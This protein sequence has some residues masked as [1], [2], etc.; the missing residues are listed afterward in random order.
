MVN[1][2]FFQL[3]R[4]LE[5]VMLQ[6]STPHTHL[7]KLSVPRSAYKGLFQG[8]IFLSQPTECGR[9]TPGL[10]RAARGCRPPGVGAAAMTVL[11]LG[12]S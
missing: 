9:R 8:A 12:G 2:I 3:Y 10:A 5:G 4:L 1:S 7:W 11:K 6:P